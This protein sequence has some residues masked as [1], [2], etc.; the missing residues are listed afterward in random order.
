M[1]STGRSFK[2]L[3][4]P[5]DIPADRASRANKN[6]PPQRVSWRN[7]IDWLTSPAVRLH[8]Y[9]NMHTQ[10]L[11]GALCTVDCGHAH[12]HQDGSENE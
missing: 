8:H 2:P 7:A 11:R 9:R 5:I 6:G 1:K 10:M 4:G 12:D 3:S